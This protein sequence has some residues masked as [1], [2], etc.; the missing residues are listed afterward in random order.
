MPCHK[1]KKNKRLILGKSKAYKD[2]D[3]MGDDFT[4]FRIK[5]QKRR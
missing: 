1:K 2:W 4:D 3:R 5:K